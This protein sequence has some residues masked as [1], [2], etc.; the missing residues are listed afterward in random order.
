MVRGTGLLLAGLLCASS[1]EAA[2]AQ[3]GKRAPASIEKSG[4]IYGG[5]SVNGA[6]VDFEGDLRLSFK[7]GTLVGGTLDACTSTEATSGVSDRLKATLSVKGDDLTGS[8]TTDVGKQPFSVALKRAGTADSLNLTGRVGVAGIPISIKAEDVDLQTAEETSDAADE[9]ASGPVPTFNLLAIRTPLG[10]AK[11]VLDQLRA[12]QASLGAL[13]LVP[14]CADMRS[15]VSQIEAT[16]EPAKVPSLIGRLNAIGGVQAR[17]RDIAE[18]TMTVRIAGAQAG[19]AKDADLVAA[20]AG[21]V[22]AATGGAAVGQPSLDGRTGE[23]RVEVQRDTVA[24]RRLGLSEQLTT[25]FLIGRSDKDR[26][27]YVNLSNVEPKLVDPAGRGQL[28]L[29]DGAAFSEEGG[30]QTGSNTT[31]LDEAILAR[32]ARELKGQVWDGETAAWK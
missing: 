9:Q 22:A 3:A 6:D 10:R 23:Y 8:G 25:K 29:S 21:A 1:I 27:I 15:G 20:V 31:Q 13:G 4:S 17:M 16:V 26:S 24:T 12:E 5:A 30:S 19:A 28:T 14:T 11:E 7:G 32:V 2:W 18:P